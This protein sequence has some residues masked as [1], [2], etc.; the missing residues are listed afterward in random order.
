[1]ETNKPSLE[2]PAPSFYHCPSLVFPAAQQRVTTDRHICL[3]LD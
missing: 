2:P 3:N 1:M